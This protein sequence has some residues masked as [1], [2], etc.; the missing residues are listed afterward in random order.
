MTLY[1]VISVFFAMINLP[2]KV[3]FG[4]HFT[5]GGGFF[6]WCFTLYL[7]MSSVGLATEFAITI[8]GPRFMAFFLIPHIIVNVSYVH[9]CVWVGASA[10][11]LS[12]GSHRYLMSCNHGST[13]TVEAC[14]STTSAA[15]SEQ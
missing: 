5:Y 14:H 2:F 8:L 6:L 11:V 1:S 13:N 3:K 12:T 9:P 10:D 15:P 4:A 7:G